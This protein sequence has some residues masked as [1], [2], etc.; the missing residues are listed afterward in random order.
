MII[1]LIVY[2]FI[3]YDTCAGCNGYHYFYKNKT[4][5]IQAA[6]SSAPQNES[7]ASH[8]DLLY[9]KDSNRETLELLKNFTPRYSNEYCIF[10]TMNHLLLKFYYTRK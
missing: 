2:C 6:H 5:Q 8:S 10:A 4:T 9:A 3:L 7:K 1:Y